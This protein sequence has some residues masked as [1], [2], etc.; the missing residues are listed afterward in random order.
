MKNLYF[1]I[2]ITLSCFVF[3]NGQTSDNPWAISI[4]ANL[5]SVQD[6]AV[7]SKIGFGVPAV[8]LS[9][10]IAGGFSIGAQYSLNSVEVDNADL[11]YAAIEAILKYNLSEG[12]VFPYL[13]AG[14]GLSNF[15]KDSSADG[16]FPS[17]GTGRTY[18]G[19]VGLNFRL[20]DN[21]LLNASTSYR[22]SN[23][24]GSFNHLQHVVGF[25]YVFGAGDTDKD[26]VSDKKDECPEVPGLKE[27]NGCPDTDGD[28]IPDNK[29]ACPEEAGSPE[30]N[31]C[32]DADG[33]GIADKDDACP[34]AAGTVEMNGC[35]DSDGDGVA[36]NID[37]CPQEAGDAAN[38]G[39]PWADRD[40]DGVADKDDTCPDEAGTVANNGC[41]EVPQKLVD[42]LGVENARLLFVVNSA[43][44]SEDSKMKLSELAKLMSDYP[45]ASIVIE[46]HASSDGSMEYNQTLSEKRAESV[47]NALVEMGV[48]ADRL[49]AVGYGETKPSSDNNSQGGRA[50]NRRVEFDR[51]VEIKVAE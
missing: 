36:D 27:F 18:L 44:I 6:D 26:G 5:V 16:I 19:G 1:S 3:V 41:P 21:M 37:K 7:D 22:S 39:C 51:K 43:A 24:K 38:D 45:K 25:S 11:D 2:L 29:D 40:G 10:Y 9:R 50:A 34:D 33:D 20:S 46:G 32:P 12:N 47:K 48:G 28:G 30:L 8:S 4:G 17:A 15:E 35:P 42:F 13:F 31:G 14:Y 23:E 49:E